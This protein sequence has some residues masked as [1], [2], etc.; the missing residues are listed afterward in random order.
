[1]LAP[2]SLSLLLATL[3]IC[4]PDGHRWHEPE[5]HRWHHPLSTDRKT[6]VSLTKFITDSLRFA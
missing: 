1:M 4:Y 6:D 5:G 2:I 3:A